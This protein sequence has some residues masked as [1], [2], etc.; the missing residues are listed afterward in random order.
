M[1]VNNII[2]V[3]GNNSTEIFKIVKCKNEK[4]T[5]LSHFNGAHFFMC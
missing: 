1:N 2:A 4:N 3:P 5:Q